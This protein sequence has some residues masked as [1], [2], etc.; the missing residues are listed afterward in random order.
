MMADQQVQVVVWEEQDAWDDYV[1]SQTGA[2]IYQRFGWK[3]V[4]EGAYGRKAFY[5]AAV[6]EPG[7]HGGDQEITGVLPLVCLKHFL[8][9]KSLISM[10]YFDMGGVLSDDVPTAKLLINEAIALGEK[11]EVDAVE[12]RQNEPAQYID[13]QD[14]LAFRTQTNKA[15]MLLELPET[16]DALMKSFKSKLRSQ[17]RRPAK[18][19]LTSRVG[20]LELLDDFYRVF[21][22][23][24][25]DLGSPVHSKKFIENVLKEFAES[26]RIVT[27]Y[28]D[29]APVAA[30]VVVGFRDILENPWASSLKQYSR[31]SPNM[32][33]YWTMLEYACDNGYNW[34]DFGRSTPDEGTYKFK[35]QWGAKPELLHWHYIYLNG[36]PDN[37]DSSEKSKFDR[38]IR[39][40]KKLPVS[41]TRFMGPMIRKHIGL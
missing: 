14:D 3:R 37:T 13:I 25:R 32:L 12:I 5:L 41:I 39:Q 34:F 21:T 8:F 2:N 4:I 22:I 33:L 36:Q 29:D 40:W 27:V 31:M 16:S 24:M 1:A 18:A 28:S 19:G 7:Q 26:S 17:I 9:G 38:A 15:R 6:R 23:N 11:L 20:G 35:K 30:S 10:P